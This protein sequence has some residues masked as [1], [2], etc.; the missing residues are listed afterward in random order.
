MNLKKIISNTSYWTVNKHLAK[1]I[2]LEAT[3][4]LQHLIDW[5]DYHNKTTIFQDIY[6][7]H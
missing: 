1:E 4:I 2:G 6:M 5:G 3:L 7:K